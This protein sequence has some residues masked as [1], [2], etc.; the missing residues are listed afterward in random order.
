MKMRRFLGLGLV[1]VTLLAY[2]G[3]CAKA[4]ELDDSAFGNGGSGVT[5]GTTGM[6]ATT[7]GGGGSGGSSSTGPGSGG[8]SSSTTSS[9]ST[10][11]TSTT[12]TGSG[13]TSTGSG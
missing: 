5:V 8:S 1:G 6:P 10:S 12:A 7:V 11:A 13:G 4:E 3:S 9:T 2:S